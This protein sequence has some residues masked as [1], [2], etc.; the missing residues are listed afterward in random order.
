MKSLQCMEEHWTPLAKL[1]ESAVK[2]SHTMSPAWHNS[3]AEL[4]GIVRKINVLQGMRKGGIE[5][6]EQVE[7]RR[8]LGS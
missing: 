5:R 8:T 4:L 6:D 1:K 7:H 3:E 2:W